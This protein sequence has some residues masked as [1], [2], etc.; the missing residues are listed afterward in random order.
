M[1]ARIIDGK[2]VAQAVQQDVA[3]TIHALRDR[4]ARPPQLDV[5]L[6]GD[7]AASATYVRGKGRVAER[8]GVSFTLH[9]PAATASTDELTNLI[10]QLN[11]DDRVD[12]IL[13]QLPLPGHIDTDTV[14]DA[15]NPEKDA[16]G[17]HPTNIG[18]LLAGRPSVIPCTPAGCMELLR[19][20]DVPIRGQ[21]AVIV[22]RSVIVGRPLALLLLNENATVTI[23][24]SQT[25]ELASVCREADIL[26]SAAGRPG[27]ITADYVKPGACVID[28][29]TTPV[30]GTLT[31]DVDRASVEPIAGWLTP[32]PGGV[33]P[34]TIAMLMHSVTQL[35]VRRCTASSMEA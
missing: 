11:N 19:R 34:M 4:G 29:G 33:G 35:A 15:V 25:Q 13:V 9:Q 2:A 6:C 3:T 17:F 12:G 21:R 28:V 16:D 31:G 5:I 10:R 7:N 26:I 18:R 20:Y 30:D 24:H 14:I 23:C 8:L 27:L 22:G 32:V 1:S